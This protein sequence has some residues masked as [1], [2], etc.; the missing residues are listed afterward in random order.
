MRS[1]IPAAEFEA[2]TGATNKERAQ[3]AYREAL[4]VQSATSLSNP[5]AVRETKENDG[6]E[7]VLHAR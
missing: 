4:P 7:R 6:I 1:R 2:A 3:G 5:S